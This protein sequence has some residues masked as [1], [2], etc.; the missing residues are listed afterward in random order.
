MMTQDS[1]SDLKEVTVRETF[2]D[3]DIKP[4]SSKSC[5]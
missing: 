4:A 3:L 5:N 2:T 1:D